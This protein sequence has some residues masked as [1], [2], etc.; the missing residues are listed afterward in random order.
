MKA[1]NG[2]GKRGGRKTNGEREGIE[3]K[4]YSLFKNPCN[5]GYLT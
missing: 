3:E 4:N 1:R 5:V 2:K